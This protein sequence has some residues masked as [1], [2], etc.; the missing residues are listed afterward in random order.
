MAMDLSQLKIERNKPLV[1]KSWLKR[2]GWWIGLIAVAVIVVLMQSNGS[3][4]IKTATVVKLWPSQVIAE[5]NATG[6]V[7]AQR[8]AAVAS[9]A[10]GRLEWLG[11]REGSVVKAGEKIAELENSDMQ[12]QLDQA[13]ANV[14]VARSQLREAQATRRNAELNFKRA[15]ELIAKQLISPSDYDLTEA[16]LAQA[17]AAVSAREAAIV[18]AQATVRGAQVALEN[19]RIL[20]PFDGI[21]VSKN[22]NVG[23]VVSP[24]NTGL[25]SKGAVVDMA[26]MNTLEVE[27]DVAESSLAKVYVGQPCEIVLDALPDVRLLGEVASMVPSVDRSKA[28]VMFKIRFLEKD[29]R[30]LPDMSAKVAFLSRALREDERRSHIAVTTD[31]VK[32]GKLF[33]VVDQSLQSV[34]LG[35]METLGDFIVLPNGFSVGDVLVLNPTEDLHDGDRVEVAE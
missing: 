13:K 35:A 22:A 25:D 31:V 24:F 19:T 26:D 3:K 32:D 34:S 23:D 16:S 33:K 9:K 7:A 29:Q 5:L 21:I 15:Q 27:A 20:A 11:V 8:K 18:A 30:V 2:Y 17:S 4:K 28:T 10:S 12:A 6:Y 1:K 14:L